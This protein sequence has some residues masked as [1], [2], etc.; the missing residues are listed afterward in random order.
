[1]T[2]GI[3]WQSL[4]NTLLASAGQAII[5]GLAGFAAAWVAFRYESRR[6]TSKLQA[7]LRRDLVKARTEKSNL[8][9]DELWKKLRVAMEKASISTAM[10][11]QY[12]DFKWLSEDAVAELLAASRLSDRQKR[13]L[14]QAH[15]KTKY[16]IEATFWIELNDAREALYQASAYLSDNRIYLP[17]SLAKTVDDLLIAFHHA[18]ISYEIW[19]SA[20]EASLMKQMREELKTAQQLAAQ[21]EAEIRLLLDKPL[22]VRL[23]GA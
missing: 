4:L 22:E 5:A 16:Y 6:D 21:A 2:Q 3:D 12:P 10:Y 18:Y 20:D 8:V 11:K 13:E 19:H 1:L 15:D 23:P 7:E 14:L 9:I 17:E